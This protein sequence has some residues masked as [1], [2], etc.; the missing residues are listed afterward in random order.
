MSSGEYERRTITLPSVTARGVMERVGPRE[1][2]AYAAEAIA[3]RLRLD[4]M[5][6]HLAET[7]ATNGPTDPAAVAAIAD[8]LAR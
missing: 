4:A 6:D 1:F 7:E 5:R 2:S 8:W 3:A